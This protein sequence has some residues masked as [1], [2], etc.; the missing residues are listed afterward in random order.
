MQTSVPQ[1]TDSQALIPLT[2]L[3]LQM[4]QDQQLSRGCLSSPSSPETHAAPD[5]SSPSLNME[6]IFAAMLVIHLSP[7]SSGSSSNAVRETQADLQ[8]SAEPPAFSITDP[9]TPI[10]T[11]RHKTEGRKGG[12]EQLLG[13]KVQSSMFQCHFILGVCLFVRMCGRV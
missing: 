6:V 9:C 12:G 13:E 5:L 2:S 1:R 11:H 7:L 10:D 8:T 3:K 4:D